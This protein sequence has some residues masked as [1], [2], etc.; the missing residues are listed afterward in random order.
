ML[1]FHLISFLKITAFLRRN[2][3]TGQLTYL[4]HTTQGHWV[5][6]SVKHPPL[7]FGSGHDFTVRKFEPHI[8]LCS[9]STEPASH[10]L[11]LS[12]S[13]SVLP[14]LYSLFLKIHKHLKIKPITQWILAYSQSRIIITTI[15]FRTFSSS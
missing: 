3:H 6:Q 4:K 5:V 8:R 14:H 1:H 15:N 9:D 11:P 7:D 10:S 12:L 13:L 2:S